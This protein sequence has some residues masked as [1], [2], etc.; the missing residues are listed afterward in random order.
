M[1]I[2]LVVVVLY[3]GAL[4]SQ[5][6]RLVS[7]WTHAAASIS[8]VARDANPNQAIGPQK[9][10]NSQGKSWLIPAIIIVIVIHTQLLQNDL[11]IMKTISEIQHTSQDA[12]EILP[13]INPFFVS[14][15][16]SSTTDLPLNCRPK[17]EMMTES[18]KACE[19]NPIQWYLVDALGLLRTDL[20]M[21]NT[22]QTIPTQGI[23]GWYIIPL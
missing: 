1:Y 15:P 10:L 23:S 2:D 20:S 17:R 22:N 16:S 9:W 19:E 12:L 4:P 6:R 5:T 8:L 13:H 3:L 11:T 21:I 18:L 14:P 7:S